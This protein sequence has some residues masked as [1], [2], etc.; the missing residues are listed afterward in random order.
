MGTLTVPLADGARLAADVAGAGAD[1]VLVSGLGGTAAFWDPLVPLLSAGHRVIRFDQRG[2]GRSS[3]GTAPVTIDQLAEDTLAVM[4]AVESGAATLLGHS[5]G[6]C[7]VQALARAAPERVGGLILSATWLRPSRYMAALFS[8]RLALLRA[9]P[10]DYALLAALLGHPPH[11]VE[12]DPRLLDAALAMAPAQPEAQE[13]MAE[14]IAALL[15]FDAGAWTGG[16]RMPRLV[17]G[18]ED[19]V[20]VP[21]FL[22]RD[23]ADAV[24]ETTSRFF[25]DGGH[26][27][28]AARAEALAALITQ[29]RRMAAD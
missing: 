20:V 9:A 27:Y 10:R 1:V 26:F 24:A 29:W 11:T 8:A 6:G 7:I 16:L 25:P 4:D 21:V 14:R 5:M 2:I 17:V 18:T 23:L 12:A 19:D 22:Q 28:V 15:S 13:V 3:R